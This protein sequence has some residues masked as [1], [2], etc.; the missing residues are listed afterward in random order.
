MLYFA[1]AAD[2]WAVDVTNWTR[3]VDNAV[4]RIFGKGP[5]VL[6]NHRLAFPTYNASWQGGEALAVRA[7]G[8]HVAGLLLELSG[9]ALDAL[10][11]RAGRDGSSAT[12]SRPGVVTVLPYRGAAVRALAYQCA[13]DHDGTH[14]PPTTQ[15][16]DRL[17]AA[18]AAA[19]LSTVWVMQLLSFRP[20]PSP[21]RW[22]SAEPR[23]R[24]I[25]IGS[26]DRAKGLA[27]LT[28]LRAAPFGR[29]RRA[30]PSRPPLSR[31]AEAIAV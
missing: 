15:Y 20:Q 11:R 31:P 27:R 28:I 30:R 23:R 14:V 18:A 24:S 29:P 26:A 25:A 3:G 12:P 8:K 22:G 6:P 5:A 1:Y 7:P 19:G 10:D 16:I 4:L 9:A 17:A 2:L 21:S 13:D